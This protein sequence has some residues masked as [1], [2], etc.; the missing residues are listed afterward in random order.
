MNKY[1]KVHVKESIEEL[2]LKSWKK[3][4]FGV[5]F[6]AIPVA[7]IMF[8]ERLFGLD[9]FPMNWMIPILLVLS[10]PVVFIFGFDTLKSGLRGFYTFYFNMDSLIALGTVVAY[11]TGFFSY[12]GFVADYSGVSSMIMAIFITGKYRIYLFNIL[13]L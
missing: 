2:E 9:I 3:K 8:S 5:W 11:F 10:F 12:F 6:F 13:M 4:L 7:I 1:H